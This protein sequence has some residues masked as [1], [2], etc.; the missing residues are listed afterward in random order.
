MLFFKSR[1]AARNFAKGKKQVVDN[2]VDAP[3]R[4]GVK[5]V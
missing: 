5:V 2:G 1:E 3:K 4:W